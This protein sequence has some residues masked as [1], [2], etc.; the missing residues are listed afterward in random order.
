FPL[1]Y[2][3][4]TV[5][6]R[7]PWNMICP[8]CQSDNK[9]G[10]KFC[11]ECGFPLTGRMAAVAAASTSDEALRAVASD[12]QDDGPVYEAVENAA[13]PESSQPS[14]DEGFSGEEAPASQPAEATSP[15]M[16]QGSG[17]LDPSQLPVIGLAGVDVDEDG[18]EFD[19]DDIDIDAVDGGKATAPA[20]RQ[21]R[22]ASVTADLSGLDECLVDA[23]YA[24]PQSA[25]RS[26]GTMEMPR[27]DDAPAPKQK[28]FRAP[29]P[30]AKKHGKGRIVAI[31]AAV[32]VV[33]AAAAVGITYQM[34]L[35]G[36][37]MP[38]NVVG[39]TQ[40]DATY[41]LEEKGFAV[42]SVQVKSDEPEGLVLF[43][44]PTG[45]ARAEKG[46]EVVLQVAVPRTIPD[47]A[48]KTRDEA[49]KLL[50][51]A[52]FDHVTFAEVKS[53]D[54]EGMVLSLEPAAGQKAKASTPVAVTVAVPYVVPDVVGKP[55]AEA[56]AALKE[57][58]YT[59]NV[60]YYYTEDVA[61]GLVVSIDP[62]A[63]T[64][65][66]S[67]STVTMNVAVS[68]SSVLLP[69]AKD[70]LASAGTISL[71]G[72][73][74]RIDSVDAVSYTGYNQTAFTITGRAVTTL[75]G[76]T[77]TGSAKQK[78]ATITWDDA[79]NVVSIA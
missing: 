26:G 17:P 4:E 20:L 72:T 44:D 77:V 43:M 8:N 41:Q 19:F 49:G 78:S 14:G 28:E 73:T 3:S 60:Q 68:R 79:N 29:D 30:N 56:V 18:N 69:I 59:A 9:E 27:I 35:W 5:A 53:D 66:A 50:N 39:M 11:N 65:L 67:G 34:E 54:A 52:G 33:A 45:G 16:T 48:G 70:Y 13:S 22:D 2:E 58:S 57:A 40:A 32:L 61:E 7:E 46:T 12:A 71:G 24:P 6:S 42:R 23:G 64:K 37:K 47:V 1:Q 10:A 62:A 36:G 15:R 38:P 75:D 55:N 21:N 25:W 63:G 74:Y 51:E 31:V 76:E